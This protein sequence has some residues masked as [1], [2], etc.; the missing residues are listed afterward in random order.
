[1]LFTIEVFGQQAAFPLTRTRPEQYGGQHKGRRADPSTRRPHDRLPFRR[2]ARYFPPTS[3]GGSM[4]TVL[5]PITCTR[6][7]ARSCSV[8][9]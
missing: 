7:S 3:L 2:A 8:S 6:P 9:G 4:R 1:M 5:S